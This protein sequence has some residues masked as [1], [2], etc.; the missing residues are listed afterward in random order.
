MNGEMPV[1]GLMDL[2]AREVPPCWLAYLSTPDLDATMEKV[3]AKRRQRVERARR[4]GGGAVCR[5]R[6]PAGRSDLDP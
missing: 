3:K 5:D 6:G 1:G 2:P 4:A